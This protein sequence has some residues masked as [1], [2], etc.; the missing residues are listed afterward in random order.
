[1]KTIC[2]SVTVFFF[3]QGS[4]GA[5]TNEWTKATSG[6]WEESAWSLGQLPGVN[7]EFVAIDN[8]GWK[9]V[10]IG[11]NTTANY[12]GSLALNNLL[13]DA[14]TNGFN[15]LL[16]NWAKLSVPLV[17]N[18]NLVIGT[19]G[20]LVSHYSALKA[21]EAYIDGSASFMDYATEDFGELWIRSSA[22]VGLTNGIMSCSNLTFYNGTFTQCGCTHK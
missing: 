17:V 16:L 7:Q 9:A 11:Q 22:N 8:A 1:M 14:P 12:P 13:V 18:S 6:N 4:L 15:T 10:T 3:L 19:N 5:Q 20:S 21:V 2:L